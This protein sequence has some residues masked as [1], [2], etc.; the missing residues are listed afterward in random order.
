[1]EQLC[2]QWAYIRGQMVDGIRGDNGAT[3][4]GVVRAAMDDGICRDALSPYTGRYYTSFPAACAAEAKQHRLR[5]SAKL[6][7]YDECAAFLRSGTGAIIFGTSC[8][9]SIMDSRGTIESLSGGSAGGHAM[10]WVS[11]TERKD[12]RGRNYLDMPQSWGRSYGDNGWAQ[13]APSCVDQV[14]RDPQSEVIGVSDLQQFGEVREVS[15]V[16]MR[17]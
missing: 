9:R 6:R 1:V 15:F 12:S 14:C 10:P 8:V 5:S 16:G 4:S 13:W 17:G 3:I 2:R 11:C 7:S